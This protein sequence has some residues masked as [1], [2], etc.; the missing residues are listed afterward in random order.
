MCRAVPIPLSPVDLER[1][2][3]P[4]TTIPINLV[5]VHL[6]LQKHY[7]LEHLAGIE[8]NCTTL[9][10]WWSPGSLIFLIVVAMIVVCVVAMGLV[11]NNG[12]S[13]FLWSS[14]IFLLSV[15][16]ID[17][18]SLRIEQKANATHNDSRTI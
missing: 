9:M 16:S 5:Q 1:S 13:V 10:V 15:L 11:Q 12:W 14:V 4:T 3:S 17:W 7:G 18:L 2:A 8:C 6:S